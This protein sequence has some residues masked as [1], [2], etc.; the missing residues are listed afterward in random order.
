MTKQRSSD[1]GHQPGWIAR[2]GWSATSFAVNREEGA[3]EVCPPVE[4]SGSRLVRFLN[5]AEWPGE[6]NELGDCLRERAD[7]LRERADKYEISWY[8]FWS[9]E[10]AKNVYSGWDY[11]SV[12]GP[13]MIFGGSVSG[14]DGT[15]PFSS[16]HWGGLLASRGSGS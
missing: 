10:G 6:C 13:P 12:S 5:S 1:D 15:F 7:K 3:G 2:P 9:P 11:C 8:N 4:R 16:R 14:G